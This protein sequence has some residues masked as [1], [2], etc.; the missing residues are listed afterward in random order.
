MGEVYHARDT[1]LE[2]SVAVKV[3]PASSASD[4]GLRQRLEREAKAVSALNHPHICTLHDVGSQDGVDFLVMELLEG[5]TLA[6]RLRR[7]ALPLDQI[8]KIG[9][10]IAEGLDAAHRAGIVHRD[11]KPSN[12]ML[13][14]SGAKLMDFGL[15][16]PAASGVAA[17]A[18]SAPLLSA[19]LT[20]TMTSPQGSPL[21][22][23]GSIVGTIQYHVTRADRRSRCRRSQ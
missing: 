6:D 18:V 4:S 12:I 17:A 15:A 7:G 19:A 3:L 13:A 23:A 16:K 1:R 11:L 10:E 20:M 21:T 2:R 22:T 14:K 9:S 8:V 5:E